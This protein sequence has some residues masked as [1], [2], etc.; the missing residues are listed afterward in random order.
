MEIDKVC[1]KCKKSGVL[2]R[3]CNRHIEEYHEWHQQPPHMVF[4]EDYGKWIRQGSGIQCWYMPEKK[5]DC[6]KY[7]SKEMLKGL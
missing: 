7:F 4:V 2:E 3:Y 5:G 6:A 1:K